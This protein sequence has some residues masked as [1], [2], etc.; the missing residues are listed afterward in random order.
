MALL[1]FCLKDVTVTEVSALLSRLD[2]LKLIPAVVGAFLFMIFRGMRWKLMIQKHKDF[3]IIH[4]LSLYSA[5]QMLNMAMPMLTGQ[6]GR[7]FLFNKKAGLKKTIVFSTVI[8]E[9]LFDA[10]ALITFLVLISLAFAFPDEYRGL[11]I[12][13]ALVTAFVLIMLYVLL[14]YRDNLDGFLRRTS[15][16][17]WPG[18]YIT[19]HKFIMSFTKGI[20]MLKSTQHMAGCLMYSFLSWGMHTISIYYLLNAFGLH[21]PIATA[22]TVMVVNTLA[23]MI[24][25][26]PGNAG[27]F[28]IAVSSSLSAFSV[29]RSD[30]VL[31][32]LA[33]HLMDMM[34]IFLLG[35]YFTKI[36]H[37]SLREIKKAHEKENLLDEV[38]DEGEIV[39]DE[40]PVRNEPA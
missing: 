21:L 33:L 20:E 22:A 7:M 16:A 34:P 29:G 1:A 39:S 32:A 23:M 11:S 9:V 15:R 37:I 25:I 17:R 31:F 2:F 26:T 8:L 35:F 6:V 38:S 3:R 30:A 12:A 36:E 19:I 4:A 13:L 40:K 10:I 5:G 28:E 18:F 14:H 27:T 24:P